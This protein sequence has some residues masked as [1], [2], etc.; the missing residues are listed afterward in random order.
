MSSYF[1][2][3]AATLHSLG[4]LPI[5][6]K[7]HSKA[8]ALAKWQNYKFDPQHVSR[9]NGSHGVGILAGVGDV[10]L[11]LF[12]LDISN[13]NVLRAM[14]TW[15]ERFG[16]VP[17]RVGDAPRVLIPYRAATA[18]WAKRA[19]RSFL[20]PAEPTKTG[21]KKNSQRLELL[22][23]GQQAVCYAEH[24]ETKREYQYVDDFGGLL[25]FRAEELPML[26]EEDVAAAIAE[27]ERLFEVEVAAGRMTCE[28]VGQ[29]YPTQ[30]SNTSH[31]GDDDDV[32]FTIDKP[33]VD[34]VT[35]EN[36]ADYLDW[37]S[38]EDRA[39]WLTVG[40]CLHHQGCGEDDWFAVWDA[41]SSQWSGY[42]GTDDV[43]RVWDSFGHGSGDQKTFRT[44]LKER[45]ARIA[46]DK[47]QR[48]LRARDAVR[49]KIAECT[50]SVLLINEVA[51]E[52]GAAAGDDDGEFLGLLGLLRKRYEKISPG[53]VGLSLTDARKA[54]RP[55][56]AKS[57]AVAVRATGLEV[58]SKHAPTEFGI[59]QRLLDAHGHELMYVGD[60]GKWFV[61]TGF[62][63]KQAE[64]GEVEYRVKETI[65]ALP[66]EAEKMDT[67]AARQ[68]LF[69][70][71]AISQRAQ[72]VRN[73]VELACSELLIATP[74]R[75]LDSDP[76]LFGVANGTID[77]R[78]GRMRNA[79]QDDRIT[80]VSNVVYDPAAQAPLWLATLSDVFFGNQEHIEFFQRVIGYAML[81][82]P[83]E[84]KV[85]IPHGSGSNG[86]STVLNTIR[87]V[88]G[89][90]AKTANSESFMTSVGGASMGGAREDILRLRGARLVYV[91]EPEEGAQLREGLIK[92]LTGGEAIPAR[93]MYA[94]STIEVTPTWVTFMPT[95]HLPIIKGSDYGIWRRLMPVP[96]TR[97]FD[98]D[99]AVEKDVS[100]YDRLMEEIPG[101]LNWCIKGALLYQ[102]S[103]LWEP[104]DIA[105]AREKYKNSMDLIQEWLLS[106]CDFGPNLEASSASLFTSWKEWADGRGELQLISSSRRLAAKLSDKGFGEKRGTGNVSFR[107]GLTLKSGAQDENL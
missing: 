33:P 50:D 42:L 37:H 1:Q 104:K 82:N 25:A 57:S 7:E 54:M 84:D 91:T 4:Y 3:H 15:L 74:A 83:V 61:W 5:P 90:H 101:I 44:I 35:T 59:M 66:K 38:Y 103:K 85:I 53:L 14:L 81:G 43:R 31:G 30:N 71:C 21:G 73:V 88:F 34:G 75:F 58:M 36:A 107:T 94:K 96:F 62:Y 2:R 87:E 48:A 70:F 100:R 32:F 67:V 55:E 65:R 102:K 105:A 8:P 19:S 86:K 68:E 52:C 6:I 28:D 64:C 45:G 17:E 9:F 79:R 76:M 97:N 11:C 72:V 39:E 106:R 46:A 24:P 22:G 41:W 29:K 27:V 80:I 69:K 89:A 78:T 60:L 51:P 77:L 95:N 12:D 23:A 99:D 13:A 93:G 98:K 49:E 16:A 20:D 92:S 40:A 10:P 26:T 47:E 63:W 56:V 18:G